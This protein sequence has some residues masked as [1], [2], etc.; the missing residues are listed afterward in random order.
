MAK[1]SLQNLIKLPQLKSR[2]RQRGP[3]QSTGLVVEGQIL[4]VVQAT[5]SGSKTTIQRVASAPLE[6]PADADVADP[7]V[8][9]PAIARALKKLEIKPGAVVS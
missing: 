9:G 2:R 6:F 3:S 4:R 7:N 1:A 8:I 5:V